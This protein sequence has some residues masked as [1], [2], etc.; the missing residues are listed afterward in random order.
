MYR[1]SLT[2][3]ISRSP[4]PP[5]STTLLHVEIK[6]LQ[7][8]CILPSDTVFV[9]NSATHCSVFSRVSPLCDCE[10]HQSLSNHNNHHCS[11]P[12]CTF[13]NCQS[14]LSTNAPLRLP[15]SF[16]PSSGNNSR[17]SQHDTALGWKFTA[18]PSSCCVCNLP[19]LSSGTIAVASR[20]LNGAAWEKR[21]LG[22]TKSKE[23]D[24][25]IESWPVVV[26]KS[27]TSALSASGPQLLA[28]VTRRWLCSPTI[29][30]NIF[31]YIFFPLTG[32]VSPFL[33]FPFHVD[34]LALMFCL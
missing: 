17:E 27:K 26:Y 22:I 34:S 30:K 11:V 3:H 15:A 8:V 25:L 29:L 24:G 23:S 2:A 12:R 20:S 31:L 18:F 28:V 6:T 1:C 16:L 21:K 10:P 33:R 13:S 5:L 7:D 4:P 9:L 32:S 19:G 14:Q